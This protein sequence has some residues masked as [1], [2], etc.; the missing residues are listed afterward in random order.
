MVAKECCGSGIRSG[1]R[2]ADGR[3]TPGPSL[4]NDAPVEINKNGA[5]KANHKKK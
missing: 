5:P 2:V 1:G 3:S 4:K